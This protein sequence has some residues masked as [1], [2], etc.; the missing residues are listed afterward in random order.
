MATITPS[1]EQQEII[2]KAFW[3][4]LDTPKADKITQEMQKAY[5]ALKM[6]TLK[7]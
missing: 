7:Q 2:D 4:L 6:Q 3:K 5:E 1:D